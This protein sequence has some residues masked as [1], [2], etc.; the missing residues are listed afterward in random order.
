MSFDDKLKSANLPHTIVTLCID[1]DI[2]YEYQKAFSRYSKARKEEMESTDQ[3]LATGPTL[4]VTEAELA[5]EEA[6]KKVKTAS[7]EFK[8]TALPFETYNEL[9]VKYP[10]REDNLMDA[11]AGYD[12]LAFPI[13]AVELTAVYLENGKEE[14]LD[15]TQWAALRKSLPDG[16]WDTMIGALDTVNRTTGVGKGIEVF[17][18]ASKVMRES[19]M[20]SVAPT[21]SA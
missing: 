10:P 18:N 9:L 21:P 7:L 8:L 1:S 13:A 17:S 15:A 16:E 20:T 6:E 4:A 2:A 19:D 5:L 14:K 12:M 11:R 3:R